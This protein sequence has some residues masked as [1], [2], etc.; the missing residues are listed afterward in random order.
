M[1]GNFK[2]SKNQ[3][4]ITLINSTNKKSKLSTP[5]QI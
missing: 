4:K 2:N 3:N 5:Y 1:V